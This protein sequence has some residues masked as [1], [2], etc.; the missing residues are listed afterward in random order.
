[1][2]KQHEDYEA[3][4]AIA[5][6]A[7]KKNIPE[8]MVSRQVGKKGLFAVMHESSKYPEYYKVSTED[9]IGTKLFLA[10]WTGNFSTIGQD[11]V[12]MNANDMATL[13]AV[14]PDTVNL[15]LACQSW[16]E[17]NKMGPLMEGIVAALQQ[18]D[19]TETVLDAEPLNF[20]KIETA[21][22][23]EMIAGPVK[24]KGFDIGCGMTGFI[25]IDRVPE[26]EPMPGDI[27]IGVPSTGLHSNGYTGARGALL[28]PG[29]E[30]REEFKPH[31]R[32]RFRLEDKLPGSGQ[33]IG[34]ALL[35]PT[36][37]YLQ[38]MAE[39][40]MLM[41][42][43]D[44]GFA[45]VNITGNGLRNF[46]RLG[47]GVRYVITDPLPK[48]PIHEL[49]ETESGW[50]AETSY[51]KQNNGMGFAVVVRDC[52]SEEYVIS[53]FQKAGFLEARKVGEVRASAGTVPVTELQLDGKKA[54]EYVGYE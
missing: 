13:G 26:Y 9:G 31:Y 24:G 21:S 34:E 10:Q 49:V 28:M 8:G 4:E 16:I 30:W 25:R 42:K 44:K 37:I 54:A 40:G 29:V 32:G 33:T 20:G 39:I 15:Y 19:V 22:L 27:I 52:E 11:L 45:A 18:C 1:M 38:A 6:E 41:S 47:E 50:D 7:G 35:T 48:H 14:E 23:D 17:E 53:V 3:S 36:A 46:N 2:A 5:I 51:R 12:A 43:L